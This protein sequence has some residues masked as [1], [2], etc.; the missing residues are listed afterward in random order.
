VKLLFLNVS[1]D[2]VCSSMLCSL[3]RFLYVVIEARE[4]TIAP[5]EARWR[6][7][8]FPMTVTIVNL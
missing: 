1:V 3:Q 7:L 6:H 5:A 2:E 4:N 8:I